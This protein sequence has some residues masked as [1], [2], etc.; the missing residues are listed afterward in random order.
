MMISFRIARF[1]LKIFFRLLFKFKIYGRENI[2]RLGPVTLISNHQ[3]FLDPPFCATFIKRTIIFL[4]RDTLWKNPIL[5]MMITSY[6]AIPVR[7]GEADVA[8]MKAVIKKLKEGR[9][10]CLFPEATRSH[11]GKI[12]ALKPGF[13]LLC[14][15]GGATI[16]PVV[17]DGGF[18][19]WPRNKKIFSLFK[20]ITV[21]Y[22][23][24]ISPEAIKEMTK[25]QLAE[26]LTNTLRQMQ[27]EIR[28]K[29]GKEPFD[30]SAV[31]P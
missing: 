2:P 19:C 23:E 14:K 10:V 28:I 18:E 27:T 16:V 30:Y 1:F 15:R 17:I 22:G 26:K 4:A 11:D 9:V 6:K 20:K 8:A 3:T 12:S 5:G 7:R 24:A 29:E 21:S 25:E 31:T 13:S